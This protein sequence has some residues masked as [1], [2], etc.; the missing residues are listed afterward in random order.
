[1][2]PDQSTLKGNSANFTVCL[3]YLGSAIKCVK[4]G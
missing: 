3:R 1:M 4:V 2:K